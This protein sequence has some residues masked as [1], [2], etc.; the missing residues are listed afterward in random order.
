[1]QTC[2][3]IDTEL[4]EEVN[5]NNTNLSMNKKILKYIPS[6][7]GNDTVG[8]S[9]S[10]STCSLTGINGTKSNDLNDSTENSYPTPCIAC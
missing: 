6:G 1:M 5:E 9:G 3:L 4:Y 2:L 10:G 8:N 7:L